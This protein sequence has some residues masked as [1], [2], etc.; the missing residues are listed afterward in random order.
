MH[1]EIIH[2]NFLKKTRRLRTFQ[3]SK[4]THF[5]LNL[6]IN[7]RSTF[8]KRIFLRSIMGRGNFDLK[9]CTKVTNN[10]QCNY[11]SI[12]KSL[13]KSVKKIERSVAASRSVFMSRFRAF[14]IEELEKW[15][16]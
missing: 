6:E 2:G 12:R 14:K 10:F 3:R 4:L 11:A 15:K 13:T 5:S 9:I 16:M 7:V 1:P 8:K